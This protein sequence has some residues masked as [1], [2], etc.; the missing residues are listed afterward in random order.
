MSQP[1]P[2]GRRTPRASSSRHAELS[3]EPNKGLDVPIAM[4]N[5]FPMPPFGPMGAAPPLSAG[6]ARP[7]V[8]L[9]KAKLHDSSDEALPS[10]IVGAKPKLHCEPE[11]WATAELTIDTPTAPTVC[12]PPTRTLVFSAM[13]LFTIDRPGL[14]APVCDTRTPPPS[15]RVRLPVIVVLTIDTSGV[16]S[17]SEAGSD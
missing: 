12:T 2:C 17:A 14:T 4:V 10:L 8:T 11:L 9:S 15:S 7:A 1:A 3:A 6:S 13:V 5:T 16:D